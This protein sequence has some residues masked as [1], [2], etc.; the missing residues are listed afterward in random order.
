MV[1]SN[2]RTKWLLSVIT[3]VIVL[4]FSLSV[5]MNFFVGRFK[6]RVEKGLSN[7]L[8]KEVY[9]GGIKVAS[10][11]GIAF[12][13]LKVIN[14]EDKS[15]FFEAKKLVLKYSPSDIF[16]GRFNNVKVA[17]ITEPRIYLSDIDNLLFFIRNH[18]LG[19]PRD[20]QLSVENGTLILGKSTTFFKDFCGRIRLV[21]DRIEFRD[22]RMDMFSIPV[23][24]YGYISDLSHSPYLDL[25]INSNNPEVYLLL[26]LDGPASNS[27]V[28][29]WISLFGR[30]RQAIQGNLLV[31][32]GLFKIKN[33]IIEKLYLIN[34]EMDLERL[35]F[36]M[37][38]SP[39]KEGLKDFVKTESDTGRLRR[40]MFGE[41]ELKIPEKRRFLFC[42]N[43]N[44]VNIF[45]YDLLLNV[46]L[47]GNVYQKD[48][49]IDTIKGTL[50][51]KNTM[52]D[53][54]PIGEFNSNFEYKEGVL[55]LERFSFG[56]SFDLTGE[57]NL[58]RPFNV[59]IEVKLTE[60]DLSS[61]VMFG[62][63]KL[64]E[65]VTGS[66]SG[67]IKAEENLL[68]PRIRGK[69]NA[70]NGR[71]GLV[72]Y[73][74]ANV[75]LQGT[76]PVLEILDSQILRENGYFMLDGFVDLR[77]LG[78]PRFLEGL[79]IR[80]DE[81]TVVWAG[82]DIVKEIDQGEELNLEKNIGEDF[83]INFKKFINDEVY[84][85]DYKDDEIELEYKLRNNKSFK[86]RLKESEETLQLQ[87]R[88]K[89]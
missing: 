55:K 6:Q 46:Y 58:K 80:S 42:L 47:F 19:M 79:R 72:D 20:I 36:M 75:N 24:M 51:T 18:R 4:I 40:E 81:K 87:H 88:I 65:S 38:V 26:N 44:H 57:I 17:Q 50:I 56:D 89:F 21:S 86:M 78:R 11:F 12:K 53:F 61:L 69:L 22:I 32:K 37:E 84:T 85:Q 8:D 43:L 5:Y 62:S 25:H 35:D 2:I 3:L 66:L 28:S 30:P 49:Y 59:N 82:W 52:I 64:R 39:Y 7:L 60:L 16:I 23:N 68:K 48:R 70:R 9:I 74:V 29:G 41:D 13:N 34:L 54:T 63:Q 27:S 14:K 76:W 45:G 15:I 71:L 73:K 77:R 67:D 33:F 1:K 31:D 10:A 83:K